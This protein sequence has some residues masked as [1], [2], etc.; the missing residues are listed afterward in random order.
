MGTAVSSSSIFRSSLA[1]GTTGAGGAMGVAIGLGV[2]AGCGLRSGI[3]MLRKLLGPAMP[4]GVGMGTGSSRATG[5]GGA[6]MMGD[7]GV[8]FVMSAVV[9]TGIS[10]DFL[11]TEPT[12]LNFVSC[13]LHGTM[14]RPP[15]CVYGSLQPTASA[16]VAG[17]NA[18][19]SLPW[20]CGAGML[21]PMM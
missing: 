20:L 12:G 10:L 19:L 1:T 5:F 7:G 9:K 21:L 4:P 14:M 16:G 11:S 2:G 13:L 15:A 3:G 18:T 8:G 6:G 17:K